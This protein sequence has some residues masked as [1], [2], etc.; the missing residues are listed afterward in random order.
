M[1]SVLGHIRS[2]LA[3]WL[4]LRTGLVLLAALALLS[5]GAVITDAALD[6]PAPCRVA[7]PWL[8]L[9]T[10]LAVLGAVIFFW[11]RFS[12]PFLAWLLEC[13][14]PSLG[15]RLTNAVDLA[16]KTGASA[17]QEF[18]RREAVELGRQS[19]AKVSVG[20]M[21]GG[22]VRRAGLLLACVALAWA[23][24]FLAENDL[25]QAVLPRFLDARGDHPPFSRLKITVT[26][27]AASV[28][29]GGQVEIHA[30]ASGRPADKLWLVTKTSAGET[31]AIMF[32]APDKSFF[33]TL[34]SLR[35]PAQ[36]YVTDGQARS[37]R[38]PVQIQFTPQITQVEATMIFPDYTGKPAHTGKLAEEAQALPEDT[39]VNFRVTSNR[40]LKSGVLELTPVLGGKQVEV[41]LQPD[42]EPTVV[43]G[44]FNLTEAVAFNLSIRDVSGLS[45]AEPKR[46]RLNILPDRPPHLFVVEPGKDAVATPSTRVP[47][48]VQATDDYGVTRVVWLRGLNRSI[49]R[50][51]KMS[52]ALKGGPKS[53]ESAAAF[54]LARLGVRPG[55][56]IDYYFEAA[57]NY[58]KGPNVV[59]SRPFRL[60]IISE[61]QYNAILRQAAARKALFESYFKL[62][63]W[64]RRLAERARDAASK[65]AQSDPSATDAAHALA[66]QL[67]EYEQALKKLL[68]EPPM[69]DVDESFHAALAAE[70]TQLA[71]AKSELAKA[72]GSGVPNPEAMKKLSDQ[73]NAMAEAE[74]EQVGQPAEQIAAVARLVAAA[75]AFVKL[76]QQEAALAQMLERFDNASDSLTRMEQMEVQELAHQQQRVQE[77]L[78]DLLEQ[79]P[80]LL[81]EVPNEPDYYPLRRDVNKFLSDVAAAKIEKYL[82]GATEAL[83][84]PDLVNGHALAKLAAEKMRELIGECNA[85]G[86]GRQSLTARFQ[87]KLCKPGLGNSLE[88]ILS[89]LGA[90]NGENGRDGYGLFNESLALYGPNAQLA[91]EQAGGQGE[92]GSSNSR[93]STAMDGDASD[94]GL[95]PPEAPG[96]VRLQ[97]EAK[98]PLRYRDLVGEYFRVIAESEKEG[99]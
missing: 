72:L 66:K 22:G 97:P 59:F 70:L 76:A 67:D 28:L 46:G 15:N 79:L 60:Q 19:A 54:D 16:H 13:T 44:G 40:P 57:D 18:L 78:H 33:Q 4:A 10:A 64:T 17:V 7:A 84:I 32:L 65:A 93:T 55:D 94:A 38:F 42:K 96:R 62:D 56:V 5:L 81:A 85:S 30:T 20:S 24:L 27:G 8:L 48:R 6:L 3:R 52:L 88:Q 25:L 41:N 86:S 90:G 89:A 71:E 26:P 98:F 87:P 31:R 92:T 45:C 47:V 12:D 73:L 99:K 63:A 82:A 1:T 36:Y 80:Q 75:D 14:D 49:E 69:F 2:R 68:K 51:F 74:R 35:E 83:D 39:R 43:A 11:R 37:R 61:E 91:G 23:A 58:P 21:E 95:P 50:P 29:F 34:A 9:V 53:V 77:G